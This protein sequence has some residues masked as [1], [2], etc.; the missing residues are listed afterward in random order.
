MKHFILYFAVAI[1]MFLFCSKETR[2]KAEVKPD[3][4]YLCDGYFSREFWNV[5]LEF[6]YDEFWGKS[7][8]TIKCRYEDVW[9]NEFTYYAPA[10]KSAGLYSLIEI[11]TDKGTFR[12]KV[13]TM[14][15]IIELIDANCNTVKRISVP[16]KTRSDRSDKCRVTDPDAVKEIWDWITADK[17]NSLV[18]TAERNY[19]YSDFRMI[20]NSR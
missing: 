1:T 7:I 16:A 14:T 19:P 12:S 9:D 15:I 10:D 8:A 13:R 20:V 3:I 17:D 4:G 18:I 6:E 11:E 5:G 2:C